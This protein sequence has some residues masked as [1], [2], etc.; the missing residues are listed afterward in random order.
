[1]ARAVERRQAR[2]VEVLVEVEEIGRAV[3]RAEAVDRI[4]QPQSPIEDVAAVVLD[5]QRHRVAGGEGAAVGVEQ[6]VDAL[7]R[8]RGADEEEQ[9][10]IARSP[11]RVLGSEV[12]ARPV[13]RQDPVVDPVRN[14]V[15]ADRIDSTRRR[16]LRDPARVHPELVADLVRHLGPPFRIGT[17]VPGPHRDQARAV[18]PAQL[19][20]G[21]LIVVMDDDVVVAVEG[22]DVG[23]SV[24]ST[25]RAR[26]PSAHTRLIERRRSVARTR[27]RWR[28]RARSRLARAG[29]AVT[30]GV[31]KSTTASRSE[32]RGLSSSS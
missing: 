1:M 4:R 32:S 31:T 25:P 14:D 27:P 7:A 24:A 2:G 12:E 16:L 20:E 17:E 19:A 13:R 10:P 26:S 22:G 5:H 11:A 3:A 29:G 8:H 30:D 18:G 23:S 6:H 9:E 15:D 21:V 28:P